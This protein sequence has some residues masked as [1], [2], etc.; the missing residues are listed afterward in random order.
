MGRLG[1]V[2]RRRL[3]RLA[4]PLAFLAAVT[5]AVLLVRA[6][7]DEASTRTEPTVPATTVPTIATPEEGRQYYRIRR[8]DT[9]AAIAPRFG[10]TEVELV[11]LNPGIEPTALRIGQRIRVK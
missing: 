11:T 6:G 2:D 10:L 8:G 5:V 4:A 3:A 1:L 9:L 7:L